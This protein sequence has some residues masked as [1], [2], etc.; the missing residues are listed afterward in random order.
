MQLQRP[1]RRLH[2]PLH[3]P[4]GHALCRLAID[5]DEVRARR[6]VEPSRRR[7]RQ[8]PLDDGLPVS[9]LVQREP[10]RPLREYAR[11]ARALCAVRARAASSFVVLSETRWIAV[12]GG[13]LER[14]K[15]RATMLTGARLLHLLLELLL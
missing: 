13:T 5:R 2:Q 15:V 6:D 7:V 3:P 12:C 8:R 14:V 4:E 9:V 11:K 1:R 10:E